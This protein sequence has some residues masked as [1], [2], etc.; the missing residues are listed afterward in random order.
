MMLNGII[1]YG[2]K[3][4]FLLTNWYNFL[5]ILGQFDHLTVDLSNI[6]RLVFICKGN[7]CRSAFAEA[8]AIKHGFKA[9]SFGICAIKDASANERAITTADKLGYNL[10]S[11]KT[12]PMAY[13]ILKKT[14]LLI[15]M[16]PWQHD[17]VEKYLGRKHNSTLL[18][19]WSNP[20]LPYIHDPYGCSSEY[21]DQC[22]N[23]IEKAVI[24]MIKKIN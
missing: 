21:F 7:I 9:I 3:K 1:R 16:E 19:L 11:H 17:F 22:F 2:S 18:G 14:D 23:F 13:P 20:H 24:N 10:N 4:G 6:E 15:S 8:V 12:T 5:G